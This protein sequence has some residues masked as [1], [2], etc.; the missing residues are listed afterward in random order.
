M[1]SETRVQASANGMRHWPAMLIVAAGGLAL[2]AW[3][4]GDG[5]FLDDHWHR[6]VLGEGDWSMHTL[7]EGATIEPSR[8]IQS[9]WQDRVV[10]WQYTRPAALA[11]M[12]AVYDATGGS[13]SAQHGVSV[14]LHIATACMVYL[15]CH[16]LT[17]RRLWSVVGGMTFA[18]YS[19]ATIAVAWLAAQNSILQTALTVAALLLY[20]RASGLRLCVRDAL[21]QDDQ[22]VRRAAEL[23]VQECTRLKPAAYWTCFAAWVVA[24]LSRENA[25]VLPLILAAFDYTFGGRRHVSRRIVAYAPFVLVGAAFAVWR[26]VIAYHPMPDVYVR[27]YDGPEYLG[28]Y[29]AKLLHY[30]CSS[31]WLSPMTIGP[32]GRFNPWVEVPGDCLLMMAIVGVMGAGYFLACRRLSGYWIW[33]AWILLSILPIVP[34]MATPHSGYMPA[35]GFSVAMALGPGLRDVGRARWIGRWSPGVAIYFLIATH[36]YMPIY[37]VLQGSLTAAERCTVESVA[38]ARPPEGAR[39]IFVINLPFV[40]VYLHTCLRERWGRAAD[41][42][43][44][45]VVTYA[46]E[47]LMMNQPYAIRQID[48]RRF[49]ITSHGR[50]YFSGFLGRFLM[51]GMRSGGRFHAGDVVKGELFDVRI[52]EADS[53]GVRRLEFE[54]HRPLADT[55]YAFY[56]CSETQPANRVRFATAEEIEADDSGGWPKVAAWGESDE[57]PDLM[58]RRDGMAMIRRNAARVIR[59]DLYLTGPPFPG[60]R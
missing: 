47:L 55:E 31:V 27:R 39:E 21:R 41:D 20:V 5:L 15:L 60:P 35:V 11:L 12:K 56:V 57:L 49:E 9:W 24:I 17:R 53:D 23:G 48:D 2:H 3:S 22:E 4:I 36:V 59:T 30:V 19:H 7:L 32:S 6:Q 26:L 13:A 38:A 51:D 54:F 29:A 28:W 25:L 58:R 14:V 8:F 42:M 37:R 33:P 34:V 46:P 45:H 52:A 40:N 44:V 10:R 1:P 16:Q 50:P 18:A 43:R